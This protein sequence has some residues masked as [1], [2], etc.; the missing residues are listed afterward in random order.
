MVRWSA[1]AKTSRPWHS[2]HHLPTVF[3]N[4]EQAVAGGLLGYGVNLDAS[5]RRA[6]YFVD[7]I[8]RGA[9]AA[10]LPVEFPTK[11]ELVINIKT[12]RDLGLEVPASLV[13]LADEIL[14]WATIGPL[15]ETL[16][17]AGVGAGRNRGA[18]QLSDA[19]PPMRSSDIIRYF[20]KW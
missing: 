17:R 8:L 5:A 4:R 18:R 10:D 12:A 2:K 3:G 6:A 9:K 20:S 14:E 16:C 7:K 13:T 11:I 1:T 19:S 15:A